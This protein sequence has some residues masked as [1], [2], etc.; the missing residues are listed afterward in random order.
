MLSERS[1]RSGLSEDLHQETG[2]VPASSQSRL[3]RLRTTLIPLLQPIM[4]FVE[5]LKNRVDP[6]DLRRLKDIYSLPECPGVNYDERFSVA[7]ACL[8]Q[9]EN[10]CKSVAVFSEG[11]PVLARRVVDAGCGCGATALGFL[12]ALDDAVEHG[13]W[14]VDL[15]LIDR[16]SSQLALCSD[17]LRSV[18]EHFKH[19]S[20]QLTTECTDLRDWHPEAGTTDHILLG[21]VLTENREHVKEILSTAVRA[22]RKGGRISV[23]ER[24]HDQIWD[25]V[26]AYV[27]HLVEQATDGIATVRIPPS[28]L[29]PPRTDSRTK[30]ALYLLLGSPAANQLLN[31][32]NLYFHC[33]ESRSVEQLHRVFTSDATYY[34]EPHKPPLKGLREIKDYWRREV[35]HQRHVSTKVLRMAL[36]DSEIFAEWQATFERMRRSYSLQGVLIIDVDQRVGK[37]VCFR[38]Y[39]RTQK[40]D[41]IPDD[42][43]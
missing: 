30:L 24:A 7:F 3:S 20:V 33:W 5:R 34:E 19:L 41:R 1:G 40:T 37:V 17:L 42:Q 2:P 23:I 11:P 10:F 36:T 32:L 14:P 25:V 28:K 21:H 39:F 15:R 4:M 31:L 18:K 12:A 8:Y 6:S 26:R 9:I 16:S 27:P 13:K 22:K 38:E 43:R 35:V 29:E